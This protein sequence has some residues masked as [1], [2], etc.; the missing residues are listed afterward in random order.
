[1]FVET[2]R[3]TNKNKRDAFSLTIIIGHKLCSTGMNPL[4]K[5]KI[6]SFHTPTLNDKSKLLLKYFMGF[7]DAECSI[8]MTI[9]KK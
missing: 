2:A 5:N 8:S 9:K 1:M 4:Y 3:F 6:R 7:V